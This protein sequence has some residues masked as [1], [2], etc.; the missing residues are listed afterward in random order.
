MLANAVNG[1]TEKH[2]QPSHLSNILMWKYI[3]KEY[4]LVVLPHQHHLI[5]TFHRFKKQSGSSLHRVWF[6]FCGKR[7]LSDSFFY[8]LSTS[9]LPLMRLCPLL[10]LGAPDV[11]FMKYNS[12]HL[13]LT[14]PPL[15]LCAGTASVAIKHAQQHSSCLQTCRRTSSIF[16][17]CVGWQLIALKTHHRWNILAIKLG[18]LPRQRID[19]RGKLK[20]Q[21][22]EMFLF[23]PQMRLQTLKL[24]SLAFRIELTCGGV[25]M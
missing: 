11:H 17:R 3:K 6:F 5:G 12:K 23:F 4:V 15:Y 1:H 13:R 19:I 8:W 10:V 9:Y 16:Y 7:N 25:R 20:C 21:V 24:Y 14:S 18:H 2:C 22:A